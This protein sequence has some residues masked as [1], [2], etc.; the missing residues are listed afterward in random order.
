MV[1]SVIGSLDY[2]V[3]VVYNM[4]YSLILT[5]ESHR[6]SL[7]ISQTKRLNNKTKEVADTT[8]LYL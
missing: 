3:S 5:Q 4:I 6:F 7:H 8:K 1:L 2:H